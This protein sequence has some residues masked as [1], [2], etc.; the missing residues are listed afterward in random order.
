MEAVRRGG[1]EPRKGASL[2]IVT[3]DDKQR[4]GAQGQLLRP[5]V[6]IRLRQVNHSQAS[7][8]GSAGRGPERSRGM[9]DG[10]QVHG[11]ATGHL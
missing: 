10:A 4:A 9:Q 11:W 7:M 1:R 5:P 8:I 3:T 6:E 2:G